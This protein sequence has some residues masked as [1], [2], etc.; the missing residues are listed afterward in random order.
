MKRLEPVSAT[1]PA[2]T[3]HALAGTD[4]D[5]GLAALRKQRDLPLPGPLEAL[6]EAPDGDGVALLWVGTRWREGLAAARQLPARA[7]R[8]AL[9]VGGPTGPRHDAEDDPEPFGEQVRRAGL[10]TWWAAPFP[11]WVLDAATAS[12]ARAADIAARMDDAFT[13]LE[14]PEAA[15]SLRWTLLYLCDRAR[16]TLGADVGVVAEQRAPDGAFRAVSGTAADRLGPLVAGVTAGPL[17]AATTR[18]RPLMLPDLEAQDLVER[19]VQDEPYRG[20]LVV[21]ATRPG[22]PGGDEPPAALALYWRTPRILHPQ[23]WAF[24]EVLQRLVR[25][26]A[27]RRGE[28]RRMEQRHRASMSA[29]QRMARGLGVESGGEVA[30]LV[31]PLLENL[32]T[33]APGLVATAARLPLHSR[34]ADADPAWVAA[35]AEGADWQALARA[36]A[37]L[38]PGDALPLRSGGV[39]TRT[40]LSTA[41]PEHL[42]GDADGALAAVAPELEGTLLCRWT[43]ARAA[44][45]GLRLA[46]GAAEDLTVGAHLL[47]RERDRRALADL[48]QA[49][50]ATRDPEKALEAMARTVRDCVDADGV[51]VRV[52]VTERGE[53]M[54][55]QLHGTG[56]GSQRLWRFDPTAT[57][58]LTARVLD[59]GAPLFVRHDHAH[60][61]FDT[62]C[63]SPAPVGE[64]AGGLFPLRVAAHGLRRPTAHVQLL[65]P[66]FAERDGERDVVGVLSVWRNADTPFDR[67]FDLA[68]LTHV[69]PHVAAACRRVLTMR[70]QRDQEGAIRELAAALAPEDDAR[71]A[72]DKT[73]RAAGDLAGAALTALYRTDVTTQALVQQGTWRAPVDLP[74]ADLP[75]W[76][77]AG[78]GPVEDTLGAWLAAHLSD[79]EPLTVVELPGAGAQPWGALVCLR[80]RR[81]GDTRTPLGEQARR[82][83][84]RAF[85]QTAG[86]LL[87]H[88]LTAR[89]ASL[90]DALGH[91][92]VESAST[93]EEL[94]A[95]A[96]DALAA[97]LA[98]DGRRVV[99]GYAAASTQQHPSH[100]APPEHGA[101]MG[102]EIRATSATA[103]LLRR[104]SP[105]V[106]RRL[107][108]TAPGDGPATSLD[109]EQLAETAAALGWSAVGSWMCAPLA[110]E[111][112]ALGA[113]TV[114]GPPD[115][116]LPLGPDD[117]ALLRRVAAWAADLGE[118]LLR[119]QLRDQL[120]AL[121]E[122]LT[123]LWGS[124]LRERLLD[125]LQ[126]WTDRAA[127]PG[128]HFA[129]IAR[130]RARAMVFLQGASRGL[131][132]D[133]VDLM[134]LVSSRFEQT[135]AR[136]ERDDHLELYG[137]RGL[138]DARMPLSGVAVPLGLPGA[139]TLSGHLF[140]LDHQAL[141]KTE[142]R[143]LREAARDIS[144]ALHAELLRQEWGVQSGVFRH[145]MRAPVQG[146][147]SAARSAV[148]H[149]KAAGGD[150]AKVES[151][152][153]EVSRYS[154]AVRL[155]NDT[156]KYFVI[157][158]SPDRLDPRPAAINL[159]AVTSAVAERYRARM[160]ARGQALLWSWPVHPSQGPRVL[161]DE[162]LYE[163][164]LSNLLDNACKYGFHNRPITIGLDQLS[165]TGKARLWV[166]DVG[167]AIPDDQADAIYKPGVRTRERDPVRAIAGEGIGLFLCRAIA[168]AHQG[169]LTH[170]CALDPLS[171]HRGSPGP[172]TPWAVR[173]T[174][175]FPHRAGPRGPLP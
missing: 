55:E 121:N 114:L 120:A 60:D 31:V 1:A 109:P 137:P 123:Q 110:H 28:A 148:R 13:S 174:F 24:V 160:D 6:S 144:I 118:R 112:R 14:P 19:P 23:E 128:A 151:L 78:S 130:S 107:D 98:P 154:E 166:E 36:S 38:A 57:E 85:A 69:A 3:L 167:R 48:S 86:H 2:P 10:L 171:A 162:N 122:D 83:A 50:A 164:L 43:D 134:P 136:W 102:V 64:A 100:V 18:G 155:W 67:T 132:H 92:A 82:A 97:E 126:E 88:H 116:P 16:E 141:H 70:A 115:D 117:A 5:A 93:V 52:L 47:R 156:H 146:L 51:R 12:L 91:R 125:G 159:H 29:L 99:V 169:T 56:G 173:F 175:T 44:R 172:N 149:L 65:V 129:L 127:R 163:I 133:V 26:E 20:V 4:K 113:L 139:S 61:P 54:V 45:D 95:T 73:L 79:W 42:A 49:L 9:L 30:D 15:S 135:S 89:I 142:E 8:R 158:R 58:G 165:T 40:P 21:P 147:A 111:G 59:R 131:A 66:L 84:T 27:R 103:R 94:V 25:E 145:A 22:E 161:L 63:W 77:P 104:A 68:S 17:A 168:E 170:T 140:L 76:I 81:D 87:R 90:L 62:R 46:A 105:G 34:A 152:R 75:A 41:L 124:E 37:A 150:P 71:R 53:P 80:P 108:A 72:V 7:R 74:A 153:A 11:G 119:S 39:L 106:L 35:G 33:S 143:L 96:V 101:L 32:R 157:A 138:V